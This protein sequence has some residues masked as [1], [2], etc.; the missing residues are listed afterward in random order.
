MLFTKKKNSPEPVLLTEAQQK[1]S[2]INGTL[3]RETLNY[4]KVIQLT[5]KDLSIAMVLQPLI[6]ENIDH[7]VD[8]F[9]D[10]IGQ[11]EELRNKIDEHSSIERLKRSIR[12]HIIEMFSGTID[13]AFLKKRTTVAVRHVNIG[14]TQEWYISSFQNLFHTMYNLITNHY[15]AREDRDQAVIVLNKL[16]N[17]EQQLVLKAYDDELKRLKENEEIARRE[18]IQSLYSTS[19]ELTHLE[20]IVD[21]SFTE[22][23]VQFNSIMKS[24]ESGTEAI[25]QTLNVIQ[26]G[27][28][29]LLTVAKSMK[30]MN[31]ATE[32][33]M[34]EMTD[35]Q[36]L[37]T[38]VKSISEIVISLAEQ[39]NLLALNAS[40]EAARAGD[41]GRGFAVVANEVR[42]LA[43]QSN[44]SAENIAELIIK[45][46]EQIEMGMKSAND[47]EEHL[48]KVSEQMKGTEE[49]FDN[50]DKATSLTINNYQSIQANI[51][52]FKDLF[53][54]VRSVTSTIS[55]AAIHI[56]KM[57]D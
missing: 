38:Q 20:E 40:I 43:E 25:N 44:V 22:M 3:P 34:S 28:K 37:S 5:E 51:D 18:R 23:S 32:Q 52:Q 55:E 9:Y 26:E 21:E 11:E 33:I 31:I 48:L 45:T 29:Q 19:E 46:N 35:L 53:N 27:Q 6:R 17:F 10:I 54:E 16:L 7:I 42:N 56:E 39:T 2:K 50:F 1:S 57:I 4:L 36:K 47:V 13:E 12:T 24:I 8:T 30:N 14:L 15:H 49:V 41:H